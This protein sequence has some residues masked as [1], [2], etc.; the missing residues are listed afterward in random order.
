[1]GSENKD[2]YQVLFII[3]WKNSSLKNE[4][5]LSPWR[6]LCY[7]AQPVIPKL[8]FITIC[9]TLNASY[10]KLYPFLFDKTRCI[11]WQEF[12][13]TCLYVLNNSAV[14]QLVEPDGSLRT[15]ET[16]HTKYASGFSLLAN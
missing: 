14:E 3:N 2:K 6:W 12:W 8:P 5:T 4:K 1:M 9:I 11:C 16:R 7:T 10:N 15:M 13:V